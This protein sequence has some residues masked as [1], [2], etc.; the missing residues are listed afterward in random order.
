MTDDS[1]WQYNNE[2]EAEM[3]QLHALH[4]NENAI[5][6]VRKNLE[7]KARF[8]SLL[9]CEDCGEE[10]AELRRK[11]IKGVRKCIGCQE[12]AEHNSKI[13]RAPL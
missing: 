3:A 4:I 12:V 13:Q 11:A 8:G 10:I 9:E 7:A 6:E 1:G 5:A 2:E